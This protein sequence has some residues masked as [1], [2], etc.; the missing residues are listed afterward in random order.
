MMSEFV[1]PDSPGAGNIGQRRKTLLRR[2]RECAQL[3]A[4]EVRHGGDGIEMRKR[5]V[6]PPQ[7]V[8]H[9]TGVLVLHLDGVEPEIGL[10][11]FA[12]DDAGIGDRRIGGLVA[13]LL[14]IGGEIGDGFVGAIARYDQDEWQ[15]GQR[16]HV[17]EIVDRIEGQFLEQARCGG[18]ERTAR[19]N[20]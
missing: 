12:A 2:R 16:R 6:V 9:R 1:I 8:E 18:E 13:L 3:A 4:L 14:E 15:L 5:D 17:F 19:R 20:E 7:V 11:E 10:I